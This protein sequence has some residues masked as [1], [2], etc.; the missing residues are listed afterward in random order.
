[1]QRCVVPVSTVTARRACRPAPQRSDLER[2]EGL[3]RE[4]DG[5][6]FVLGSLSRQNPVFDEEQHRSVEANRLRRGI[7][8]R[9]IKIAG[10]EN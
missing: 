6:I 5:V 8:E 3:Q 9:G 10:H 4:C 1:M 7:A 2:L